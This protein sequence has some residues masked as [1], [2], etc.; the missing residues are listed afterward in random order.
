MK[1]RSWPDYMGMIAALACAIHCA[2]LTVIFTIYP[3][4]WLKRKYWEM[5]LWQKLMWLEWSLLGLSWIVLG[6]AMLIGW[7]RHRHIGPAL[8]GLGSLLLMSTLIL[9]PLHFSGRWTGFA[10]LGAGILIALSHVWN[11][12]LSRRCRH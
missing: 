3:T 11:L 5:G 4:L 7:T 9:T 8:V 12:R 10:A 2:A 1:V 6:L